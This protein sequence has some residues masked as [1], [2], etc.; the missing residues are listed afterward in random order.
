MLLTNHITGNT[1]RRTFDLVDDF[2][3]DLGAFIDYVCLAEGNLTLN[4]PAGTYAT[5]KAIVGGSVLTIVGA[6]VGVTELHIGGVG[7]GQMTPN[8]N[9]SSPSPDWATNPMPRIATVSAGATSVTLLEPLF[10][11]KFKP[12]HYTLV[13][14]VSCQLSGYPPN[15]AVFEFVQIVNA[16]PSTGV[17][18]LATPL[19]NS[20]K[21]TWID[22]P[23]YVSYSSDLGGAAMIWPILNFNNANFN[24]TNLKTFPT[25][26][27]WAQDLRVS[28]CTIRG[29]SGGLSAYFGGC[30]SVL[31]ENCD[32]PGYPPPAG[33]S[34][35]NIFRNCTVSFG[36]GA[37]IEV[38]KLVDYCEYDGCDMQAS[39]LS[40]VVEIGIQSASTNTL[41]IHGCTNFRTGTSKVTTIEN[42]DVEKINVGP[43]GYGYS[44]SLVITSCTVDDIEA[45]IGSKS[46]FSPTT[47]ASATLLN[48]V[49]TVPLSEWEAGLQLS[50]ARFVPGS[51]HFINDSG[52]RF[53]KA[54]RV[55]D[56]TT[57]GSNVL[58]TTDLPEPCP[59]WGASSPSN[60]S[61]GCVRHPCPDLTVTESDGCGRIRVLARNSANQPIYSYYHSGDWDGVG[62][63]GQFAMADRSGLWG[64]IVSMTV[65]VRTAYT[66]ALGSPLHISPMGGFGRTIVKNTD[67][68]EYG[69]DSQPRFGANGNYYDISGE[70]S[71]V[72]PVLTIEIVVDQGL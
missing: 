18:N 1:I 11:Y 65:N 49:I 33:G 47:Q 28:N 16:N 29:P 21:S 46:S 12:G 43:A 58:I 71:G 63:D 61:A 25:F 24:S 40:G 2:G 60:A 48:G 32:F 50:P 69:E 45:T 64:Q 30:Y 57:S 15:L 53:I 72:R 59:E 17:V 5:T 38:D 70:A 7:P 35:F 4:V 26:Q 34:A 42:C 55:L 27:T 66:G 20:Y 68:T 22:N 52:G 67:F 6:G 56:Y 14:G 37:N 54:F 51:A 39:D 23:S 36:H 41:Y 9:F 8:G 31:W 10:A 19:V 3:G 62:T 13:S 44:E